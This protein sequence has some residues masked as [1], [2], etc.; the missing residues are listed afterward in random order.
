P[1]DMNLGNAPTNAPL[2]DYL[3]REFVV[4]HFDLKWLHREILNSATYQRS[5]HSPQPGVIDERNFSRAILRRL[6]AEVVYDALVQATATDD[7]MAA[8]VD[9]EAKIRQRAIG[10]ASGY[11]G[12]RDDKLYAVYLFGKPARE[13][14]CDCERSGGPSLQQTLFLRND[15]ELLSLL[16]RKDGWLAQLAKLSGS[17]KWP[18]GEEL[19]ESAYLRSL[20]RMPTADERRIAARHFAAAASPREGLR[21]LMWAL[22]NTKEFVVNH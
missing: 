12:R 17:E 6:P 7:D 21:D 8:F 20:S 10:P 2:L 22:L 5:W 4:R 16:D 1:D 13:I 18:S 19:I 3:T 15:E 9:N 11:S 14:N